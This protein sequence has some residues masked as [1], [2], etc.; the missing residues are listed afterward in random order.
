MSALARIRNLQW[1]LP[2]RAVPIPAAL[3]EAEP[4]LPESFTVRMA[5]AADTAFVAEADDRAKNMAAMIEALAANCLQD[6]ADAI[7]AAAGLDGQPPK[8]FSR[9]VEFILRCVSAPELDREDV[10]WISRTFPALFLALFA[11]IIELSGEGGAV[12][13]PPG[14]TETPSLEPS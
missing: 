14:S 11:A 13:K 2:T 7:K 8:A 1:E 12:G 6:K 5:T 3:R 10:L 9:Q 4:D